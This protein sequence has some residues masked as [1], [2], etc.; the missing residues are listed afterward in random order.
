MHYSMLKQ[1]F[2]VLSHSGLRYDLQFERVRKC[3][4]KIN[5]HKIFLSESLAPY[6]ALHVGITR[7]K[8]NKMHTCS[9]T[10]L[11]TFKIV[12]FEN[13]AFQRRD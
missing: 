8:V 7:A 13:G 3:V 10:R 2:F 1:L 12:A 5:S 11:V 6:R 9:N 4:I